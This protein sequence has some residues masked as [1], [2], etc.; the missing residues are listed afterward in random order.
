[1]YYEKKKVVIMNF[2]YRTPPPLLAR[3]VSSEESVR[4]GGGLTQLRSIQLF[5]K[6]RIRLDFY[7]NI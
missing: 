3:G 7:Y 2:S 4:K 5:D 1:M 6:N